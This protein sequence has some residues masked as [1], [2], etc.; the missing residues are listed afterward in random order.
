MA[1]LIS[2]IVPIYNASK[3]LTQ[4][5]ESILCQTYKN[6]EIIL[7]DDGSTDTSKIICEK[8]Q[9]MDKRIQVIS[10]E[11]KGSV[12]ARKAGMRRAGGIYIGFVDADDY[13]EPDMFEKLYTKM[14]E[15][16]VDFVHTGMIAGNEKICNFKEEIIEFAGTDRVNF[17][18]R[19]IFQSQAV[20]Y[21]LWSKLFKADLIKKAYMHL[22]DEQSYG[23]D[24]LC[25]CN[26]I[27]CCHKFYMYKDAFYHYRIREKSLSHMEGIDM[28]REETRLHEQV[29]E[30]LKINNLMDKCLNSAREYYKRRIVY[31]LT[32]EQS[33]GVIVLKYFYENIKM[34][35]NK[36][37]VLYGAGK[38][39]KDFYYQISRNAQCEIV[40]WIDKE[41]YGVFN[42]IPI[43]KPEI[44]R[45]LDFDI[46]LIAVK[47]KKVVDEIKKELI[48]SSL[49]DGSF[50]IIW[51]EPICIL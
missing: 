3:Y 38:V 17:I 1:D 5:I 6:L 2:I 49:Y 39:G 12:A 19:N 24:L 30:F 40:A 13:I 4:C 44:L 27:F 16:K 48:Q 25:L 42:L 18:N 15:F 45:R 20:F 29:V 33:G 37:I 34:L 31:A 10:Q 43:E 41:N 22:P 26:Y 35:E 46:L 9:R 36:R 50:S 51:Q 21:A 47:N 11:N 28:C 7:I 23:E 8:Y 32:A 14:E